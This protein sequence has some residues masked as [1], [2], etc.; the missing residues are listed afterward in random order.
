MVM[1][2]QAAVVLTMKLLQDSRLLVIQG[3]QVNDRYTHV[4]SGQDLQFVARAQLE[5]LPL[6]LFGM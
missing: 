4:L 1:K 3:D 2:Q 5:T 6:V